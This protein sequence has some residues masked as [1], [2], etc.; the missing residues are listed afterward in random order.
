MSIRL[1]RRAGACAFA[2]LVALHVAIG[3][4]FALCLTQANG[5]ISLHIKFPGVN[6]WF[7]QHAYFVSEDVKRYW[8]LVN[9]PGTPYRDFVSEYPPLLL[10]VTS[11]LG[12]HMADIARHLVLL[13]LAFDVALAW[14]L[15]RRFGLRAANLYLA[16]SLLTL[17]EFL[18]RFDLIVVAL[19]IF[20]L[21]AS[22]QSRRW[23]R[24]AAG[25]LITAAV[26]LKLWPLV[27]VPYLVVRR[28]WDALIATLAALAVAFG[29]WIL[30][31]GT[32][33]P[34][35]VLGF[36]GA[37]GWHVESTL[38]AL[39]EIVT[40]HRS[41][42]EQGSFRTTPMPSW[43]G[44]LLTIATA[45]AVAYVWWL[46]HRHP[47]RD[48][49]ATAYLAATAAIAF[50]LVGS[51]LFSPQYVIWLMP[52]VAIVSAWTPAAYTP[53]TRWPI[54]LLGAAVAVQLIAQLNFYTHDSWRL[55]AALLYETRNLL[56]LGVGV[57]A[58]VALRR[59]PRNVELEAVTAS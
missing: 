32:S 47:G 5:Q 29:V 18:E 23:M 1:P 51:L 31:G 24:I 46:A 35:Q 36:R 42:L 57:A 7:G 17:P 59:I 37:R 10:W 26:M 4:L 16:V 13:S 43:P 11:A 48:P 49:E 53:T 30:I 54:R 27:L 19:A 58:L 22:E 15:T 38:G 33:G 56:V 9:H 3:L 45:V 8:Q 55:P 25:L 14:L 52:F 41:V 20:A 50:V 6:L 34:G 39:V 28:R 21:V 2:V 40:G 12:R 44:T